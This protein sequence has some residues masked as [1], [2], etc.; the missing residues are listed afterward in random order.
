MGFLFLCVEGGVWRGFIFFLLL[1]SPPFP[2]D[3][4]TLHYLCSA[5]EEYEARN[6]NTIGN[7]RMLGGGISHTL[8]L[9]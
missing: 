7:G 1:E 5:F 6:E 8:S 3:K 9:P 4:S 2:F